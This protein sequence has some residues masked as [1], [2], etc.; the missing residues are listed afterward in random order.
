M[1]THG[2]ADKSLIVPLARLTR[3]LA[4]LSAEGRLPDFSRGCRLLGCDW[5]F[6]RAFDITE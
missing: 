6:D 1:A 5:R 4:E 2:G 3:Q